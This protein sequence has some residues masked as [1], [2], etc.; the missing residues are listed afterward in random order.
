MNILGGVMVKVKISLQTEV[1]PQ[2][3]SLRL[4][5]M[6]MPGPNFTVTFKH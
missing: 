5:N 2:Q 4:W 3:T 6:Q 1:H